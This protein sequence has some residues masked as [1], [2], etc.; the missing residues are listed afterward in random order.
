MEVLG[1]VGVGAKAERPVER[2][3]VHPLVQRVEPDLAVSER[4]GALDQRPVGTPSMTESSST[5]R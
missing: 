3:R 5:S 1:R 2:Q 4:P